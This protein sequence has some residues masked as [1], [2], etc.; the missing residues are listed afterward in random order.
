MLELAITDAPEPGTRE[1]IAAPLVAFNQAAVGRPSGYRLLV[2][3]IR[4]LTSGAVT[5]GLW[6]Y[7]I[8]QWLYVD[9]LVVPEAMRRS[10]LGTRLMRLAED[11]ARRRGCI[12]AWLTTASFQARPF[13]ENLG[14]TVFST[15]DD[16]P[17]G[18]S[19]C[20]LKKRLAAA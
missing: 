20:Y 3:P 15:I 8:W 7:S 10:G 12:G 5:G 1:A 17:P 4:D 9:L 6:G 11:E 19:V 2:I 16:C 13:Y 14:Y 18:H